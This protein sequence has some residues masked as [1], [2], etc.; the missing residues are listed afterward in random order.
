MI[1]AQADAED[2][3]NAQYLCARVEVMNPSI[4]IEV[5]KDIH[6]EFIIAKVALQN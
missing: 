1:E 3:Q 4:L 6:I 2:D 5:K